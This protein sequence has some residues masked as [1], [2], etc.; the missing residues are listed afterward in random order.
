MVVIIESLLITRILTFM[1][2]IPVELIIYFTFNTDLAARA[3]A[4]N[5]AKTTVCT[6][7]K[8][9]EQFLDANVATFLIFLFVYFLI[10]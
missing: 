1:C 7:P 2:N 5:P 6:A 4:E 3:S 10:N 9:Y 8:V